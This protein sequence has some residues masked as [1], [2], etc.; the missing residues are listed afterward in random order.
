MLN[1]IRNAS[2]AHRAPRAQVH[3]APLSPQLVRLLRRCPLLP[4]ELARLESRLHA[5]LA[6]ASADELGLHLADTLKRTAVVRRSDAL[7]EALRAWPLSGRPAAADWQTECGRVVAAVVNRVGSLQGRRVAGLALYAATNLTLGVRGTQVLFWLQQARALPGLV[8]EMR[9]LPWLRWLCQ[10]PLPALR[11]C[12]WVEQLVA[13]VADWLAP[14]LEPAGNAHHA[15]QQQ[16]QPPSSPLRL[17]LLG[18][19]WVLWFRQQRHSPVAPPATAVG[20]QAARLPYALE[21]VVLAGAAA[22]HLF[23]APGRA[24]AACVAGNSPPMAPASTSAADTTR[25]LPPTMP[26]VVA[27]AAAASVLT[28]MAWPRRSAIVAAG[29]A[30]TTVGAG[31]IGWR[32][33]TAWSTAV[34]QLGERIEDALYGAATAPQARAVGETLWRRVATLAQWGTPPDRD[35]HTD[36]SVV[37][38]Q[39]HVVLGLPVEQQA[40]DYRQALRAVCALDDTVDD[41][42]LDAATGWALQRVPRS[43]PV[44]VPPMSASMDAPGEEAAAQDRASLLSTLWT[45]RAAASAGTAALPAAHA[46]HPAGD[47]PFARA[48]QTVREQLIALYRD[49]EFLDTLYAERTP[50]S[51]LTVAN[52]TLTGTRALSNTVVV[53]H[54]ASGGRQDVSWSPPTAALLG[55]LQRAVLGAGSC[56]DNR[57][58]ARVDCALGFYLDRTAPHAAQS[59]GMLDTLI[60]ALERDLQLRADGGSAAANETASLLRLHRQVQYLK[61]VPIRGLEPMWDSWQPDPRSH[62]GHNMALA[63]GVLLQLSQH[64]ELVALC[65]HHGADASQLVYPASGPVQARAV[66]DGRTVTLFDAAQPPAALSAIGAMLRGLAAVLHAPVRSDG[67][68]RVPEMLAYYA[69]PLPAVPMEDA[70]FDAC[71]AALDEEIARQQQPVEA[72]PCPAVE[73]DERSHSPARQ[74]HQPL[75][76]LLWNRLDALP[77]TLDEALAHQRLVPANASA[78]HGAWRTAQHLLQQVFEQPDTWLEMRRLNATFHSLRVGNDG[79]TARV[80]PSGRTVV[81]TVTPT[82]PPHAFAGVLQELYRATDRLG[83]FSPGAAVPLANALQFHGAHPLP[84]RQ[85]CNATVVCTQAMLLDAIARVDDDWQRHAGALPPWRQAS[86]E[87]Q[88]LGSMLKRRPD[89]ASDLHRP[90]LGTTTR[91]ILQPAFPAFATL[92]AATGMQALLARQR[93]VPRWLAVDTAGV[94]H[95]QD[96]AGTMQHL[97][98]TRSGINATLGPAIDALRGVARQLG[99]LVRSDGR[100][101]ASTV[102]TAHGGCGPREV[103]LP[104]GTAR[105]VERLLGE[106][107]LG[108]RADLLHAG[109]AVDADGLARMRHAI[110]GFVA[111]HVPGRQTLLEYLGT[112]LVERGDVTWDELPRSSHFLASVAR[113]PSAMALQAALL[114]ALGWY[115]GDCAAP[116]SPTLLASLTRMAIVLD[117]GPASDRDARV[118]LGYRLHKPSNWGRTFV[119]IRDDFHDYLRSMGR[120]PDAMIGM[121]ATLALQDHAPELLAADVPANLVY[122][123]TIA[124]INFISGV[125]LAERIRRG[126][127]QQLRFGELLSLSADLTGH[128]DNASSNVITPLAL[129]ARRLPTLDWYVFRQLELQA[130]LPAARSAAERIA[131]ALRAFDQRVDDIEQAI[132]DVLAPLP[133]RMPLVEAEIQRAF[134]RFPGVLANAPWNSTAFRLFKE[135]DPLSRC[136]PFHE[137]VAAGV[138]RTAPERWRTCRSFVP[139][140]PI[141][142]AQ[143]DPIHDAALQDAYTQMTPALLTL[144]DI[145]LRYQ[146]RFDA[147]FRHAR[148]GYGLLIEEALYQRPE[149]ERAALLR[150]DVEVFTLRTHEPDLEAQQETRNDTEPYRGRFAVVYT[151][152]LSGKPQHFQL[153]PLQSR[154]IPLALDGPLPL[155]GVLQNRKVRLRSGNV[156]TIQVRRGTPLPV[157][158]DAYR[159]DKPPA[160]GTW[161]DVIVEPL[162]AAEPVSGEGIGARSPFYAL[163]EPIQQE[164]FWLDPAAFRHEGWAPTRFEEHLEEKPLWL[165]AVD[166]FVPFVE[167]LRSLS[168]KNRNEFALA[169]FGLYLESIIVV[170][171]VIGGVVKVLA[172]PGLAMTMPRFRDLSRVV[173]RG[174]ADAFNPAA[175]SLALVRLG[176]HVVQRTARGDL[177]FLWP[178]MDPVPP[179]ARG[180]GMRWA[181]REGMAIA[182]DG[183]TLASSLYATRI[184]TV[185]GIPNVLVAP[186]P[187]SSSGRSLHLIDPATLSLYGPPLEERLGGGGGAAGALFKAGSSARPPHVSPGK[188]LKPIKQ[189][190]KASEE[191]SDPGQAAPQRPAL[192]RPGLPGRTPPAA[193]T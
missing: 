44:P 3:D 136:F 128:G 138:L 24:T 55:G 161:S 182:K 167:N 190:P 108:M 181:M 109:D 39:V 143:G 64:A 79:L 149:E 140:S 124:S 65:W 112:P 134:P 188:A 20:R 56:F 173:A 90:A 83:R 4:S 77:V 146:E 88:D 98:L 175:G 133:Y 139:G 31:L 189:G 158:W 73:W 130:P 28:P 33:H 37:A 110:A 142:Q 60:H 121:A 95:L 46:F 58:P 72:A 152:R 15:L 87:L 53:L 116:T 191:D 180:I 96:A 12:A 13:G 186:L 111:E 141:R 120:I 118:L 27:A 75:L 23:A 92:M 100:V 166:F 168:S 147:Y 179:A 91:T 38:A 135:D 21:D 25:L 162:P 132:D 93:L 59:P 115:A 192:V 34:R 71:L 41:A 193:F 127:S 151:L 125:H 54:S 106:L 40:M 85:R 45:L 184:R 129:D 8:Q 76:D 172:R 150:G 174:T 159:S 84:A 47:S 67:R 50:P 102:L 52:G 153:F 80:R 19:A 104:D 82:A 97:N 145:N 177:R 10:L 69:A 11:D 86:N 9:V 99:G 16:L 155:G 6:N 18:T 170:G 30:A 165:K 144:A 26:V 114:H 169:A 94:V 29:M 42:L 63:R 171:P 32:L 17:L 156:A 62:L 154:I 43:L 35:V 160:E 183:G 81:V 68:L 78:L 61:S 122:A 164:L 5:L 157:D 14:V 49:D 48:L 107:R 22:R 36:S 51:S 126:L 176:V 2:P 185:E 1:V 57:V 117:L 163:V 187:G 148:R 131:A 66:E 123:N 119:Q 105:C 74:D 101:D 7:D 103:A 178:L 70:Q 113:T 137:L 89:A